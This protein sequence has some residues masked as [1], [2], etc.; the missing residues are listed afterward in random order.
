MA[1]SFYVGR[2]S[3]KCRPYTGLNKYLK[4]SRQ[5]LNIHNYSM[6]FS[7]NTNSQKKAS[8]VNFLGYR[9]MDGHE[10]FLGNPLFLSK[11]KKEIEHETSNFLKES[12]CARLEGW[13]CKLLS[14]AGRTTLIKSVVQG[15]RYMTCQLSDCPHP[16]VMS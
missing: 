11:K 14:Q 12:I 9:V 4:W 13:K 3:R 5:R 15:L 8:L 16:S 2:T 1:P 6:V 10:T 7:E